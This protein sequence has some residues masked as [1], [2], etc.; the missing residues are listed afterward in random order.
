MVLYAKDNAIR[1]VLNGE[2]IVDMDIN[3]WTEPGKNPDGTP[4]KFKRAYKEMVETGYI[5]LQDHGGKLW[6]RNLELK[7]L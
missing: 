2:Q 5:G 3:R 6:F 7:K 4:N 1:I